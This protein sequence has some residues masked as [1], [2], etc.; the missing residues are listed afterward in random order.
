MKTNKKLNLFGAPNS[1]KIPFHIIELFII[2][3]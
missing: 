3:N 1:Q 2:Q